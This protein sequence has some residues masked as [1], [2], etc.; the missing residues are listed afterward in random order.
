VGSQRKAVFFG[1][2]CPGLRHSQQNESFSGLRHSSAILE[3]IGRKVAELR[4][5]SDR[6]LS[7]TTDSIESRVGENRTY[8]KSGLQDL[9]DVLR[10]GIALARTKLLKHPGEITMI[11]QLAA[12]QRFYVA[13]GKWDLLRGSLMVAA[14]CNRRYLQLWSGAA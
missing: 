1:H 5:I 11:P 14:A 10:K 9:R 7:A 6:L 8:V 2:E 3:E 13:E 12:T 4:G